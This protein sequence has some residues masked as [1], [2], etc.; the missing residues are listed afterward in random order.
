[1]LMVPTNAIRTVGRRRFVEFMDGNVKRS[2]NI[3]VGISTD[4]DTEVVTGLDEGMTIL[5]GT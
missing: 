3:E 5:A 1:V 2:R 4:V